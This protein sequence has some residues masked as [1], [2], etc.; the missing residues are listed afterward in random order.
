MNIKNFL[1]KSILLNRLNIWMKG[2]FQEFKANREL[3]YYEREAVRKNLK[4]LEGNELAVE[5]RQRLASR[6]INPLE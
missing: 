5:I 3:L 4:I 2:H 6:G 1:K